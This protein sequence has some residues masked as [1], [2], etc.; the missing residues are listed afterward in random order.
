ML[1]WP[2]I[3]TSNIERKVNN[4]NTLFFVR[5]FWE[6]NFKNRKTLSCKATLPKCTKCDYRKEVYEVLIMTIQIEGNIK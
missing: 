1:W 6:F 4:D 5:Y 2:I 3:F